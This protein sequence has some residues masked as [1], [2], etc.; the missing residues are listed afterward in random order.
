M[1]VTLKHIQQHLTT[2]SDTFI[3]SLDS[4]VNIDNYSK[5]I[6]NQAI[7]FAKFDKNKLVGLVAAY[8]NPTEKFGWITNVSVDP[9][10]FKKGIASELLN[11]CYEYFE[12]K[13]Y[14]SI[15]LEVFLDNKKAINLYLKQ[16]FIKHKI[17]DNKMILKQQLTKRDYNKELTDTSDHKY[18]Y[19]FDFDV[20]HKYMIRSFEPFFVSGSLLEL[21]SFKGDFTKYLGS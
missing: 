15:F 20:M 21:G 7:L 18:A 16:G 19:N 11:R 17:K 6:F 2:C 9:N 12:T 4:Y 1:I 8:D 10:Y 5:K 14:F 13:K 3:P